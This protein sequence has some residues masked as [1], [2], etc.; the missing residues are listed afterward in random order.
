M[1]TNNNLLEEG[2]QLDRLL[3]VGKEYLDSRDMIINM[4]LSQRINMNYKQ[5]HL[6]LKDAK[7]S[8]MIKIKTN[9]YIPSV[10]NLL[11]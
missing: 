6:A 8:P 1:C 4:Q 5:V 2:L 7:R 9:L 3:V 10:S 11:S